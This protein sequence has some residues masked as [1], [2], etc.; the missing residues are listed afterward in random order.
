M[1]ASDPSFTTLVVVPID[2]TF[3]IMGGIEAYSRNLLKYFSNSG[4]NSILL[5]ISY[6]NIQ[7]DI[8][9]FQFIPVS[10]GRR[11]NGYEYLFKLLLKTPFLRI[12]RSTIIYAQKPEFI[13][14]FM[15]F[16]S[17]NKK[18]V[19]LHGNSLKLYKGERLRLVS[20]F[21]KLVE[22]Y[23]LKHSNIIITTDEI[24]RACYIREY[25]WIH[26]K[27]RVIPMAIDLGS[28]RLLDREC[29]RKQYGFKENEKIIMY[30]GRIVKEKNLGFLLRSF[31]F[32]FESLP[33]SELVFVGDGKEMA[34]LKQLSIDLQLSKVRFMG[35]QQPEKIPEI[36]NCA[37]VLVLCSTS[38]GSPN[39]VKEALACGVPVVSTPVGDVPTVIVN[40]KIGKIVDADPRKFAEA[41]IEFCLNNQKDLTRM[42][43]AKI[44]SNFSFDKMGIKITEVMKE[45]F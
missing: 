17:K 16:R 10:H 12:P 43:C 26:N 15:L 23:V 7:T 2:P 3:P 19:H 18:I 21:Y 32:V 41:I 6:N 25:P 22:S 24:T 4:I 36:L 45:L 8:D 31:S 34:D 9:G 1:P 29:L 27:M 39:V 33:K 42:E 44:A 35:N 40:D 38:E 14:P 11:I 13:L 37:D 30:V 20:F 28:F 5:G